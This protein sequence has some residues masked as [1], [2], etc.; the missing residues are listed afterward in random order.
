MSATVT[1]Q[2][3][4]GD[5][6]RRRESYEKGVAQYYAEELVAAEAFLQETV[7]TRPDELDALYLLARTKWKRKDLRGAL[8]IFQRLL[9]EKPD[10]APA[11]TDTAQLLLEGLKNAEGA[12]RFSRRA[13]EADPLYAPAYVLLGNS[14][15]AQGNAGS[16]CDSYHEALRINP[17]LAD[18]L[19]NLGVLLHE[20]GDV[21]GALSHYERALHLDPS[22]CNAHWNRGNALLAL[23]RFKDGWKEYEYRFRIQ[24]S[25]ACSCDPER[26]L[27]PWD[28]SPFKGKR[29]LV[30][31]EQGFGDALQFFRFLPQVKAR[32]GTVI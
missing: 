25:N 16:A 23:G 18:P 6:L 8:R 15:L 27:T 20:K 28:G 4:S 19:V 31:G 5:H 13:I 7:D 14:H 12:E 2:G 30:Y 24:G 1:A 32:G 21:A 3:R 22:H 11:L 17:R 26:F 9:S 29:L 10:F